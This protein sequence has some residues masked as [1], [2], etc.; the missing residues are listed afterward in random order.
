MGHRDCLGGQSCLAASVTGPKGS[1]PEQYDFCYDHAMN[2]TE[3][4]SVSAS[5]SGLTPRRLLLA[6]VGSTKTCRRGKSP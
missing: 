3:L 5:R 4:H 1:G 6:E 2:N